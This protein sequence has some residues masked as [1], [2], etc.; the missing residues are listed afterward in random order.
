MRKIITGFIVIATCSTGFALDKSKTIYKC[1]KGKEV[2]YT[3]EPC[4]GGTEPEIVP[5]QGL[6][7]ATGKS[8]K[9]K[10]VQAIE[11]REI[12][13]DNFI[14]PA[15]GIDRDQYKVMIERQKLPPNDKD[16]CYR[17]DSVLIDNKT[18]EKKAVGNAEV[19]KAQIELYNTRKR[20]KDLKC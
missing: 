13:V 14:K 4:M 2:V 16:E 7:K 11:R 15:F 1:L 3:D 10:D 8:L 18:T 6:D 17:L 9:G 20:F 12:W 19:S 5:T